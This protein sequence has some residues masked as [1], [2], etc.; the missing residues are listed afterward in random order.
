ELPLRPRQLGV[1]DQRQQRPVHPRGLRDQPRDRDH[2]DGVQ[3]A[4]RAAARAR[5]ARKGQA[6]GVGVAHLGRRLPQPPPDLPH[7]L[8]RAG[9]AGVVAQLL[10]GQRAGVLPRGARERPGLRGA[11][12]ARA[13]QQRG[14]R[15][16]H[17]R[18]HPVA[19]PRPG[20]GGSGAR[21][22]LRAVD[23]ARDPAAGPAADGPGDGVAA[24]HAEQGHD[25]D[26]DHRDPGGRAQRAHRVERQR[27]RRR[28]ERPRA[29]GLPL[30]RAAVHHRE[31]P[32]VEALEAPRATRAGA[33][34]DDGQAGRRHRGPGRHRR[35]AP[36]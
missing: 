31:P 7:P 24:H 14:A 34:R 18:G 15:G 6:A 5:V 4:R 10:G 35:P 29:P 9:D 25:A 1:A 11:A 8:P 19:R 12:R 36:L 2:R 30:H 16:D 20:R 33:H 23:A 13:L 21:A 32:P 3:P 27:V 26:L 28:R 17:A 22:V